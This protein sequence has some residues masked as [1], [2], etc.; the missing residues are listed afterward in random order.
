M[1]STMDGRAADG[2]R[3]APE[4]R[5]DLHLHLLDRQIVDP[6]G[7]M[8]A[9]VDDLELTEAADEP[10]TYYVTGILVGPLALGPRLGGRL[11]HWMAAVAKRLSPDPDPE[12]KRIDMATGAR[13]RQRHHAHRRPR[14]AEGGAAGALARP[15]SDRPDPREQP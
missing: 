8:V 13:H 14:P 6:D 12:P 3:G 9:K 2:G 5:Y 15:L 11:G 10:G 1:S 4:P 7:R